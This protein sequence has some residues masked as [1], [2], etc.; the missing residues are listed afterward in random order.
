MIIVFGEARI[1]HSSLMLSL[2][3]IGIHDAETYIRVALR[4]LVENRDSNTICSTT[5]AATAVALAWWS[6]TMV[7]GRDDLVLQFTFGLWQEKW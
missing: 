2:Y 6:V 4:G 7:G 5:I 3:D 1:E